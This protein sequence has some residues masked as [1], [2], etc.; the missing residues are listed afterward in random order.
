MH[1]RLGTFAALVADIAPGAVNR[2]FHRLA[3]E[4]T[5][6]HRQIDFEANLAQGQTHLPIDVPV[7]RRLPA[8]NG[9]QGNHGGK[10]TAT[11][12]NR[13]ATSGISHEPGTHATSIASRPGYPPREAWRP[14]PRATWR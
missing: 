9:P 1:G 10:L 5:E 7:V 6:Q 8:N 14:P 2:L 13:L 4:N 3:G 12:A 11:Q